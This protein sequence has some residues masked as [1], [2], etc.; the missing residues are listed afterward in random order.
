MGYTHYWSMRKVPKGKARETEKLYRQALSDATLVANQY[1]AEH[2]GLSGFS[3]HCKPGDYGGFHING[4]VNS[5][6]CEDFTLREHY[7]QNTPD[8]CKTRQYPYDTVVTATL[9]ILKYYLGDL[10]SV[11]SDGDKSDWFDGCLL[12]Q[13][14]CP[15]AR[16]PKS[17]R[18]RGLKAV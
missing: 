5:G 12:A 9:C 14:V 2:G 16:I 15:D 17:I 13:T 8:F 18:G 4:S 7:K 1:S 3:A 11:S 6:S 10:I